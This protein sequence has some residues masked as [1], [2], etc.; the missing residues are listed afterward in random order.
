MSRRSI[1]C[2]NEMTLGEPQIA[3]GYRLVTRKMQFWL[4]AWLPLPS[5]SRKEKGAG[6]WVD[7]QSAFLM[8][9]PPKITNWWVQRASELVNSHAQRCTPT[10]H[11]WKLLSSGTSPGVPPHLAVHLYLQFYLYN[12]LINM[13]KIVPWLLWAFIASY[14]T[15]KGGWR[16]LIYSQNTDDKLGP[17]PVVCSGEPR[18]VCASSAYLVSESQ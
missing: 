12:K 2:S 13:S 4:E 5:S 16:I 8:K 18:E 6:E 3:L 11:R 14:Q 7:N 15:R 1:F 10:L 17:A 9:P